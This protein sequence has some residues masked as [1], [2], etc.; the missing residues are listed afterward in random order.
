MHFRDVKAPNASSI[1]SWSWLTG[2]RFGHVRSRSWIVPWY[3][4]ECPDMRHQK[5][6]LQDRYYFKPTGTALGIWGITDNLINLFS[7]RGEPNTLTKL[8]DW[9]PTMEKSSPDIPIN[10]EVQERTQYAY[11][12]YSPN[13]S[14]WSID[15]CMFN[16]TSKRSYLGT[17]RCI[18]LCKSRDTS[19]NE[20]DDGT[21][22]IVYP[23]Y[24]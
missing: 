10:L 14:R 22:L 13:R 8:I 4:S 20:A 1:Y 16:F 19:D 24:E 21:D 11:N 9:F 23:R 17:S 7:R 18:S 3:L 12:R 5:T 6:Y 15:S 2:S